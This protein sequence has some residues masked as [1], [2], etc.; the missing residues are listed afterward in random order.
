MSSM[1]SSDHTDTESS[2][3]LVP[4]TVVVQNAGMSR[5]VSQQIALRQ[6][7][8]AHI[9]FET[10]GTFLWSV[11]RYWVSELPEVPYRKDILTWQIFTALPEL[12]TTSEF[13]ELRRYLEGDL[14]GVLRLQ[15]AQS[16]G[17]AFDRYL[18][19]RPQLINDW[20]AGNEHHWQAILWR[21]IYRRIQGHWGTIERNL[22][23]IAN[24][25]PR[26]MNADGA[27]ANVNPHN[28][29]SVFGISD[30]PPLY[31][32]VFAALGRHVPI[33]LFYLNPCEQYWADIVDEQQQSK[34]RATARKAGLDDPTGLLDIGNP[35]LASWGHAG[36]AF[37]DQLLEL[38]VEESERFI[39]PESSSLL[40]QVQNN[41][42]DLSDEQVVETKP[43]DRS[44]QVH[45]SHS[46]LRE[47]QILHD[48]LLHLFEQ[49]RELKPRDIIV[50]APDIDRY[51]PFVDATFALAQDRD[52]IPWSISDRR[53]RTEQQAL[54]VLNWLLNLPL[55]RFESTEILALFDLPS[56]R[57]KFSVDNHSLQL[58]RQWVR[59][60]GIRWSLDETMRESL[61]LPA[62]EMN[63][64]KF[65]LTRLFLGY[66][67]PDTHGE[68]YG[69]IAPYPHVEGAQSEDLQVLA[70]VVGLCAQWRTRL[71]SEYPAQQWL[72]LIDKLISDFF[73]PDDNESQ[74]LLA[75]RNKLYELLD[76]TGALESGEPL[77]SR[78]VVAEMYHQVLEDSSNERHFLTGRVTFS[79][80]VPMRSIPFKVVCILGMNAEDFPRS[81]SPQSFDL[82][83]ASPKRGD[84]RRRND[85]R[86]LFLEAL[87]SAREVFYLSYVGRDVRDNSEKAAS[88]VVTE[89]INYANL[90]PV[91]HPLQP[92][93][94]PYFDGSSPRL[95][96]YKDYWFEAAS[97]D[98][99]L[100]IPEFFSDAFQSR[101]TPATQVEL[102]E[103]IQYVINPSVV[104]LQQCLEVRA[105]WKED[106][107]DTTEPFKID[108]LGR[109]KLKQQAYEWF[110]RGDSHKTIRQ[111]LI[112]H[113]EVP[114]GPIGDEE[115]KSIYEDALKIDRRVLNYK[116]EGV[117]DIDFELTLQKFN[118][119]GR[120][121]D[122]RR[123]G[124][125]DWRFGKLR[126]KDLLSFW[127]RH[128][129]LCELAE[130]DIG[131]RSVLVCEDWTVNV[132][133]VAEPASY[134]EQ[135][136]NMRHRGLCAPLPWFPGPAYAKYLADLGDG[137]P[138]SKWKGPTS[139]EA[140][141]EMRNLA[142][143][144]IWRGRQPFGE[145]FDALTTLVMAPLF[146]HITFVAADRDV[147]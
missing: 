39:R 68:L 142:S 33:D 134:L 37:L 116:T 144:T 145:E 20:E 15:L 139:A 125:F 57:N 58:M 29:I 56:V 102:H 47:V 130:T 76:T 133:P 64:W 54:E 72:G 141:E 32:S 55:S 110:N 11:A 70:Q 5:W 19:Y 135:L 34:R 44:I 14:Q 132:N 126:S 66:A 4:A 100:Q 31:T 113:G 6:G 2:D 23:R 40:Q 96:S 104:W 75:A 124:L 1:G 122:V 27:A 117:S 111:K 9:H 88:T 59:E 43:C 86:Y 106:D 87:L 61:N 105:A 119:Y 89:L 147:V 78:E 120:V 62:S 42:L 80:M 146:E 48:Q 82:M 52:Y 84:R 17:N 71:Q 79:N 94:R 129:V 115:I 36:Q 109:W 22:S 95:V 99:S 26:P 97:T 93:S 12:L 127:I 3:P 21:R 60:S 98:Q 91:V 114:D 45:S 28:K 69:N 7:I 25:P 81:D 30:M 41:I 108:G 51:A 65:G 49:H 8:S 38:G 83:A 131:L 53:M 67:L 123:G 118:L 101:E 10:P 73:A 50:M 24:E 85:D 46:E 138:A 107:L 13:A 90:Q 63:S 16:I 18:I 103:L 137:Y 143:A 140:M 128:L 77:L 121:G 74:V 92:F 136:L 35:L 112:A